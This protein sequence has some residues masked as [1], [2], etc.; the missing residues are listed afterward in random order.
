MFK[1]ISIVV[2]PLAIHLCFSYGSLRM[3]RQQGDEHQPRVPLFIA[4]PWPVTFFRM[5]WRAGTSHACYWDQLSDHGP[6]ALVTYDAHSESA[7]WF[8]KNSQRIIYI[9]NIVIRKRDQSVIYIQE[10]HFL[11]RNFHHLFSVEA[12]HH[13]DSTWFNPQMSP[14][15]CVYSGRIWTDNNYFHQYPLSNPTWCSEALV[16]KG[17]F[18]RK[19]ICRLNQT[20]PR[21]FHDPPLDVNRGVVDQPAAACRLNAACVSCGLEDPC[22]VPRMGYGIHFSPPEFV[23]Y[24]YIYPFIVW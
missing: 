18:I 4:R 20:L 19:T 1:P 17:L 23:I 12:M 9:Y 14:Q 6:S 8:L 3:T 2:Y 22:A 7:S 21:S 5:G 16:L 13:E 11:K 10:T 24:I 15:K